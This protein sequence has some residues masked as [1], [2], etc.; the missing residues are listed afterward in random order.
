MTEGTGAHVVQD[1]CRTSLI[2]GT[3]VVVSL[4]AQKTT[5]HGH[6]SGY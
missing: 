3:L 6:L 1:Q 4:G 2:M 5:I